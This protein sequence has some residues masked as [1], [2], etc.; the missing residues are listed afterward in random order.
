MTHMT[1][2]APALERL[3]SERKAENRRNS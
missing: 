3:D 2:E 1:F